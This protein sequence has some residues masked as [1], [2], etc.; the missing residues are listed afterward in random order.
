MSFI[1]QMSAKLDVK[2]R[3]FFPAGFRRVLQEVNEKR[4]VVRK[5]I[6]ENCLVVYPENQ[7]RIEVENV[8]SRL[9]RFDAT[10]QKVYRKL[11]SEAQEI[12]LDSSG[13][14][15]LSRN[16]LDKVGID[17][18]VIFVGMEQT[19]EIWAATLNAEEKCEPFMTDKEFADSIKKLMSE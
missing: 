3:V 12:S 19:V 4:L 2:N 8:R 16:M 9:S 10:Q 17:Q 11:V 5:D 1:G 7:W 14:I 6:F 13:R 15:L 18:D